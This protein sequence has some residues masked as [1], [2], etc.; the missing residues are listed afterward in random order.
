MG[1]FSVRLS[2]L[3][4]LLVTSAFPLAAQ[5]SATTAA[6]VRTGSAT[7]SVP[8][9]SA[10][11]VRRSSEI[12][13][14]ARL[15]DA[16]WN[17]AT[18]VSEF[19]QFDPEEGKPSTQ[20]TEMR[21]LFDDGSLYVGAR[22]YDSLGAAGVRATK[23]RR[24]AFFNSDFIQIVI[25]GHH[26]HLSRAFFEVNPTGSKSDYIGIGTSCCDS[27]WDP[28]WEVAT[29]VDSDGW[30]AEIR[31]PLSQLRFP[32][33]SLQTWGLQLRRFIHRRNETVQWAFWGKK[34]SGG[35]N[36]FGHLEGLRLSGGRR[37]VE[38]LPYGAGSVR[39]V[40]APVGD[41]F[42]TGNQ[43]VGRAGLDLKYLLTSSLTLDAS[44]NPDFGQVEVDPAVINLSAFE[45]S[46]PEKRPFF[47]SSSGVFSFGGFSCYFCSNTSSLSAFYTR[48]IGRAPTGA[49]LA[50]SA[51]KYADVPDASTILGSAKVTGRT[52]SGFTVGLL[53]AVTAKETARIQMADGSGSSRDVEP[54]TNYFVARLKKDL[55]GGNLTLGGIATSVVRDLDTAFVPLLNR[56]GEMLGTDFQY[57]WKNRAY[58]VNG[59]VAVS[60]IEADRRVITARQRNSARY[61]Q[62]PDLNGVNRLDTLATTMRGAAW[63][64]RAAKQS[65]SWLWETAMSSRTPGF[66]NND[67]ALLTRADYFWHNAN[68]FRQWTKP[69]KYYRQLSFILGGQEQ[70]TYEGELNDRQ[71]QLWG[72]IN[73]R[74]FWWI[75][76]FYIWKPALKDDRLLR[77][78]PM[79]VRP[80]T[81]FYE[82]DI[83]TDSR[84]PVSAN[85]GASYSFNTKGGWGYSS[86]LGLNLRPATN[87]S[88]SL[89]PSWNDSRALL[90]YVRSVADPTATAFFG[91]R[92]VL[93]GLRQKTLAFDTRL[94]LTVSPRMTFE[95]YAQPFF[96]SGQYLDFKEFDA[97]GSG[98]FSTYGV[99]KGTITST[100]DSTGLV[101]NYTVDPDG[102][103]PATPFTIQN[104]SFSFASLRGNAVFRWEFK[105]GSVI[106]LAWTHA[107]SDS[108]KFGDL[109]LGRDMNGLF[110]VRGDNILLVKVVWWLAI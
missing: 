24:D 62:R 15:D 78:G 4:V 52:G 100:L 66:E 18:P 75:S 96:A 32:A 80:G 50:T 82:F 87:I 5:T 60:N 40:A 27:G 3:V 73:T 69:T 44:I 10:Q 6:S 8:V 25:D 57:A 110:D 55:M 19:T 59:N 20:R 13:L 34:E 97:P 56:H 106:Y 37:Y 22:M 23:V 105:P 88:M 36:R 93:G 86:Y 61:F 91:T 41:P 39:N 65:G 101:A 38:V 70:W 1:S 16:A 108:E 45:T 26:D 28:I 107:R 49:S 102:A 72:Q 103:G 29:R 68:I 30:T 95:L 46:F 7:H 104:P 42:H 81:G 92:Y 63:Y 83:S 48:R 94:S 14:D 71:A 11:A 85:T 99:D 74:N 58:V 98:N 43:G 89:S 77:G 33:D 76:T 64:L 79:V 54:L 67:L 9:P 109:R 35:P 90:Q 12:S 2:A 84:K 53:N 17:D 21:F 47:V 51:G 31:I